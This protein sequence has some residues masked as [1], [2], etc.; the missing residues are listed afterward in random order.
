MPQGSILGPLLFI[1]TTNDITQALKEYNISIYADD[2][3]IIIPG[4]NIDEE[5]ETENN[6]YNEKSLLCNPTKTEIILFGTE[7]G[8]LQEL[9]YL[10]LVV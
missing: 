10:H 7:T 1:I 6:Y 2:M 8:Q 5:I 9:H 4:K 3:Q